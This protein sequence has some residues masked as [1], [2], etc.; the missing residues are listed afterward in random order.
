MKGGRGF[1]SDGMRIPAGHSTL[2]EFPKQERV[3]TLIHEAVTRIPH[4]GRDYN[5][6]LDHEFNKIQTLLD[7]APVARSQKTLL[8]GLARHHIARAEET[9]VK[10]ILGDGSISVDEMSHLVRVRLICTELMKLLNQSLDEFRVGASQ[11]RH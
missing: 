3:S 7:A 4:L 1:H 8:L 6:D 9:I 10:T 11:R 5:N 2:F